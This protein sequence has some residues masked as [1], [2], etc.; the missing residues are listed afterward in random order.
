VDRNH[1]ARGASPLDSTRRML[2]GLHL[3]NERLG[4]SS[5]P[6]LFA[7]AQA[8]KP[9]SGSRSLRCRGG[10]YQGLASWSCKPAVMGS[11][12]ILST[13]A[14]RPKCFRR[15]SWLPTRWC[16]FESRRT[17]RRSPARRVIRVTSRR[18]RR[19]THS[20][21]NPNG[22]GPVCK[23][24][25]CGFN[26]R[27]PLRA[28]RPRGPTEGRRSSKPRGGSSNLSEGAVVRSFTYLRS[29]IGRVLGYEPRDGSSNL[30]AG[31]MPS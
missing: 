19:S 16:G 10:M 7:N 27:P 12:P 22:S 9:I 30:P 23:T 8:L 2:P 14:A 29:S 24:G 1:E 15:H 28:P 13:A 11:I 6:L 17:L 18:A 3:G 5:S 4:E 25:S 31:A 26:S 20:W 21:R